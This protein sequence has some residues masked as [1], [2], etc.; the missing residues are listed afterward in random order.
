MLGLRKHQNV[1]RR[2]L[3]QPRKTR[4]RATPQL[5][6]RCE[7]KLSIVMRLLFGTKCLSNSES[8]KRPDRPD[9]GSDTGTHNAGTNATAYPVL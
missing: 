3:L 8:N 2:K 4:F 6:R 9:A 7:G 5:G 1:R